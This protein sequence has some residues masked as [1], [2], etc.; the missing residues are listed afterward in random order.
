MRTLPNRACT[1]ELIW[2][3]GANKYLCHKIDHRLVLLNLVS[4]NQIS[5]IRI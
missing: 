4:E 1:L 2:L 5:D 3:T